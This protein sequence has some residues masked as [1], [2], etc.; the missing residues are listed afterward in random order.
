MKVITPS[1]EIPAFANNPKPILRDQVSNFRALIDAKLHGEKL[2]K[3]GD[4]TW[5]SLLPVMKSPLLL[6]FSPCN[7]ASMR[8]RKLL[9]WSRRVGLIAV[10]VSPIEQA[11]PKPPEVRFNLQVC[12][13]A[14]R[15]VVVITPSNEIPAFAELLAMQFGIYESTKVANL[16]A[17][18]CES[19]WTGQ[20]QTAGGQVQ[21][22]SL[23]N[24]RTCRRIEAVSFWSFADAMKVITPSNEIPAFAELLAMQ[25]GIY[26]STKVEQANP[27]PPEVRFNLQVC[28]IAERVVVLKLFHFDAWERA[29]NVCRC[30]E[31]HYSQ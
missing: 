8:A 25:F 11:N 21:S 5:R 29:P 23:Y 26:E 30:H 15:V 2:S 19:D 10:R 1:N 28:T 3:S 17:E 16:I 31:G 14:E 20:S 18:N 4:F 13:I 24:C 7:L 27:K 22:P 9:T 12:T 6:S